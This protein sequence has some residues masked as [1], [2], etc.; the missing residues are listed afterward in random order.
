M[1]MNLSKSIFL[2]Q[3]ACNSEVKASV[4]LQANNC[5]PP[6]PPSYNQGDPLNQRLSQHQE[7]QIMSLK[8]HKDQRLQFLALHRIPQESQHVPKIIVQMNIEHFLNSDR[9]VL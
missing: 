3:T 9:L 5:V 2:S 1:S 8:Q 6:S 7:N 4:L